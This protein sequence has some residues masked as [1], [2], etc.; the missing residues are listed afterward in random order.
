MN[1]INENMKYKNHSII[2][3]HIFRDS[4]FKAIKKEI[5][6]RDYVDW[7]T[8][9]IKFIEESDENWLLAKHPSSNLWGE[10]QNFI[11]NGI[12]KSLNYERIPPY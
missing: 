8:Q 2:Y 3:L 10:D 4:P 12:L 6:F 5:L 7:I 9:T 11:I 1:Q